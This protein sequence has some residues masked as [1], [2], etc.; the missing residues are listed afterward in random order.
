MRG[1]SAR[2]GTRMKGCVAVAAVGM[3]VLAG[4]GSDGRSE[5][6]EPI[7]HPNT[8]AAL[9]GTVRMPNGQFA[10]VN[11]LFRFLDQFQLVSR[12]LASP[13]R[14]PDIDPVGAEHLV[15]L[16]RV[17]TSDVAHGNTAGALLVG[18]D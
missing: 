4:C 15:T 13:A 2:K 10:A 16:S 18:S 11:P 3:L 8:E 12:A 9:I 1:F 6:N 17:N 7:Q 14:H 5:I